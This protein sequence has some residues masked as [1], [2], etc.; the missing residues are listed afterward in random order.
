MKNQGTNLG[1]S[2]Y[3]N[4]RGVPVIVSPPESPHRHLSRKS[5]PLD[6]TRCTYHDTHAR[7]LHHR[8][9]HQQRRYYLPPCASPLHTTSDNDCKADERR[10]LNDHREA[11]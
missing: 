2:G 6:K 9:E 10:Q 4:C 8:G 5:P 1:G 3:L 7:T 11:Y